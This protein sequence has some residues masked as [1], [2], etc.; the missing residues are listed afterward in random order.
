V[1]LKK[2]VL[3]VDNLDPDCSVE[4]LTAYVNELNVNVISCF[5]CKSWMREMRE[6]DRDSDTVLV[7]SFRLCVESKDKDVVCSP[8][9]WPMGVIVRD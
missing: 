7:S 5:K 3:H 4:S 6:K 8:I 1:I 9:N 2:S